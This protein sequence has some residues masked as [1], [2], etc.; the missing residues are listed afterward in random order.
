VPFRRRLEDRIRH[1][2]DRAVQSDD[3]A[4]SQSL[5]AEL[6]DAIRELT[7]RLRTRAAGTLVTPKELPV[8]KRKP[9]KSA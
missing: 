4:Q 5:L 6:K 2:C 8:E 7:D 9:R 1:L 3:L